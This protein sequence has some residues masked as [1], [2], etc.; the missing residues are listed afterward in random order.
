MERYAFKLRG[1]AF[2]ATVRPNELDG[3]DNLGECEYRFHGSLAERLA[4][5]R[6]HEANNYRSFE[7]SLGE[8]MESRTGEPWRRFEDP[9]DPEG[10]PAVPP[11][12]LDADGGIMALTTLVEWGNEG[13]EPWAFEWDGSGSLFWLFHDTAHADNDFGAWEE[14]GEGWHVEA[15]DFPAVG[16]YREDRA[17]LEGARR[18]VACG[19]DAE[20]VLA[21]LAT[22]A[23]PF[24]ARFD[25]DS[26][27]LA[28]FIDG[29]V[30][31]LEEQRKA[32][33]SLVASMAEEVAEAAEDADAIDAHEWVDGSDWI[34]S[35]PGI[36]LALCANG[37]EDDYGTDLESRAFS[38]LRN[39]VEAKARELFEAKEGLAS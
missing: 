1:V 35:R 12:A 18:A 31:G 10:T 30:P 8:K 27:A 37:W 38:A 3:S 24:R 9:S 39:E 36:V 7:G 5:V 11:L 23:E 16:A 17:N 4:A 6:W 14:E 13:G 19:V 15:S 28:D 21:E 22:L 20:E 25:E 32:Y 33:A 29:G 26:T 34:Q 2:V